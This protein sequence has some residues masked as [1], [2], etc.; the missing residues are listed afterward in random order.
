MVKRK[1]IA[2][3]PLILL[4]ESD[5]F[6]ASIYEKNLVLEGMDVVKA[7]NGEEALKLAEKK[8][9][10]L[11][12]LA[13]VLP[14]LNGFETLARLK[15][16]QSTKEIPVIFI[17]QLGSRDDVAKGLSLGAAGYVIKGH[18]RPSEVVDKVKRLL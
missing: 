7:K 4:A 14:R 17:T 8:K 9:P 2:G 18:F 1:K 6:L 15:E 12:I 3:A 13:A 5:E 16:N 11:I 10:A